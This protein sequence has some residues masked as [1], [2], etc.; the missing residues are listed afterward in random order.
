[1]DMEHIY[2]F[3]QEDGKHGTYSED[4]HY[5]DIKV[6]TRSIP[7]IRRD[8]SAIF[9]NGQTYLDVAGRKFDQPTHHARKILQLLDLYNAK[10]LDKILAYALEHNILDIK[11]IK[12]LIKEKGYVIIHDKENT[13][14]AETAVTQQDGLTRSCDYYED[15]GGTID[16]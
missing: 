7:Q 14:L 16:L 5:A 9:E 6:V 15:T 11:S 8:F 3:E 10:D 2:T 1:M 4:E 12:D 13:A